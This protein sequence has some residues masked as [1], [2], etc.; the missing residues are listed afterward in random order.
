MSDRDLL[1]D[2]RGRRKDCYYFVPEIGHCV[3]DGSTACGEC[4]SYFVDW[5]LLEKVSP[6]DPRIPS[7][8]ERRINSALKR[9]KRKEVE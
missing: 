5:D 8:L 9:E 3:L 7:K 2:L 6:R 1:R 4:D